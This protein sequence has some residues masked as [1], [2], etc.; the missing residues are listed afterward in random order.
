MSVG[1]VMPR[2]IGGTLLKLF[3]LSLIV[4]VVLSALDVKPE[5][6]LGAIGG[7]AEGIFNASSMRWNGPCR[8]C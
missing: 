4:G 6:L 1:F 7:T 5:S 2:N 8:L 3:F